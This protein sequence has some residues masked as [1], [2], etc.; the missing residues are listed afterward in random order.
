MALEFYVKC[1]DCGHNYNVQKKLYDL[2]PDFPLYCPMCLAEFPR[3]QGRIVSANF[4]VSD[5]E[6]SAERGSGHE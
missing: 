3:R 2:G 5:A 4:P 1:P 6:K